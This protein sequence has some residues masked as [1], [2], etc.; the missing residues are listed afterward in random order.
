MNQKLPKHVA[1]I[2]DGNGR[3]AE[4]RGLLR[5]EGHRL[6]LDAV[7]RVVK[8]CIKKKIPMLSLWA[9]SSE[10]W[11]RPL[12]EVAFLMQL[13]LEVLDSE[14][15]ELHQE[16]ISLRF[17]GNR[18]VLLPDLQ[19]KMTAAEQLTK[20]N[21]GLILNIL[22]NYGGKWD[23]VQATKSL[24]AEA[25][26]G[27][28]ESEEINEALFAQYLCTSNLPDPDLFIRTS[29]EQRLSNFFLWQLAYTELYFSEL[30][31]P[32]FSEDEFEKALNFFCH[33]ERRYGKISFQ[34]AALENSMI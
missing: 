8:S 16:K 6:G 12:E 14:V 33:R 29:G 13:F 34:V 22:I 17:I 32:D 26:A 25:M 24:L 23:I 7:K 4:H 9:F 27:K 10:N 11:A 18:E 15:Q 31:W 19:A 2:M 3:W 28:I 5:S 30:Y 20:N 21:Q 1:I